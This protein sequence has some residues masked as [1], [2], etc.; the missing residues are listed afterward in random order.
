MI[1]AIALTAQEPLEAS[2]QVSAGSWGSS[3]GSGFLNSSRQFCQRTANR[4]KGRNA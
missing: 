4:K 2:R 3:S 1:E